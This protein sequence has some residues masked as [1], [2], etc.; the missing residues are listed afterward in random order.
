MNREHAVDRGRGERQATI[1][2]ERSGRRSLGRPIN[3]ALTRRH[4]AHDAF[5]LIAKRAQ[6]GRCIAEAE[7]AIS[8]NIRPHGPQTPP[9]QHAHD[10]AERIPIEIA[11]I[12]DIKVHTGASHPAYGGLWGGQTICHTYLTG[13]VYALS[14]GV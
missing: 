2:D 11:Q 6:I 9:Q 3:D 8:L 13:F 12:D 4:E 7:E 14:V 1:L 10:P 5:G